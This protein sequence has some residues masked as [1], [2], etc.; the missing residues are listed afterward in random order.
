MNHPFIKKLKELQKNNKGVMAIEI[1]IGL[2]IFLMM[3]CL[4]M[5]LL[6]LTWKFSVIG[7][8]NS[9][10]ARTAGTQG[11]VLYSAPEGFPG[12]DQA[13]LSVDEM[14]AKIANNFRSAG[15]EAGDYQVFVNG[16]NITAGASSGEIDY[17]EEF[18]TEIR[19]N[20]RWDFI[21]NFIPGQIEHQI[22]SKR[23]TLSEFKYRY[24]S[25]V[26]E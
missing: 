17:L 22:G 14:N 21:N 23:S 4:L 7:Q 2:F 18:D 25:W 12:G 5:D 3:F 6:I 1:I 16:R 9:F 15:I 10:V 11:G 20:Y 8:T 19:V 24:D 26:G 13:Y